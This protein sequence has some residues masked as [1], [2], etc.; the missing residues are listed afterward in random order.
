MKL[1]STSAAGRSRLGSL[2][3]A[4]LLALAVLPVLPGAAAA[5]TAPP[6]G[7]TPATV[8]ADSLPTVQVN[9]VVWAQ[10][11]VGQPGVRHRR[12]Q[13]GPAGRRRCR[14][15]PDRRAPTSSPTT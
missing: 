13:P 12:V 2:A 11:V 8:S 4:A 15:Q 6:S 5:D 14:H 3:I 10:V 1:R 9:G 7:S